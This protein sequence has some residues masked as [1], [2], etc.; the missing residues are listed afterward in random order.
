[1]RLNKLALES[2]YV[3]Q[4]LHEWIDLIF[5]YKQRGPESV[6]AHNVFHYLS[7]EGNIDL[8]KITDE[9][10]KKATESQIN[11]FGQTPSQLIMK[12]PHTSRFSEEQCWKPIISEHSTSKDF[13]CF[14]PPKQFGGSE[15]SHGAAIS[16]HVDVDRVVVIYANFSIVTYRW[17]DKSPFLFKMEKKQQLR[18]DEM[19]ISSFNS[20]KSIANPGASS[21]SSKEVENWTYDGLLGA[22][23]WSFS[24]IFKGYQHETS[25]RLSMSGGQVN[26]TDISSSSTDSS[27]VLLSCGSFER[28]VTLHTFDGMRLKCSDK[29]GHRGPINCLQTGEDGA[30]M[31][32]GGQDGTCR[33]WTVE[34]SSMGIALSDNYVQTALGDRS[35]NSPLVCCHVLWGHVSAIS[36]I[37]FSSELDVVASGSIDGI[38]CIHSVRRGKF[39]RRFLVYDTSTN[40]KQIPVRKLALSNDGILLAHLDD[41]TLKMYTINGIE[42]KSVQSKEK[43]H[44]MA[45][46]PGGN[47]LVTGGES[48]HVLIRTLKNL[49]ILYTIDLHQTIYSISF[50]PPHIKDQQFMF[51]GTEDGSVIVISST[52]S[53]I[54]ID[55]SHETSL[56]IGNFSSNTTTE[57]WK[58]AKDERQ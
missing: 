26:S 16:I 14:T 41:C 36:A 40:K 57:W 55:E 19:G 2:E 6:K 23:N 34:H 50:T 27:T 52:V 31:I 11:H 9:L 58:V 49:D 15:K 33:V 18:Y 21:I 20:S 45:I 17:A 28:S 24:V 39:V 12:V 56:R 5:G 25:K 48:G 37:A 54:S 42:L 46:V 32:T 1:M 3:S 43:L 35:T 44:A 47:V 51:V 53:S 38:I 7:Y 8:D 4:H 30:L 10:D 13:H 29:G 22:G